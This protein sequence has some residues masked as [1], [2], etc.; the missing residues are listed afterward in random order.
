MSMTFCRTGLMLGLMAA[1]AA[2][3]ESQPTRQAEM[4]ATAATTTASGTGNFG[5]REPATEIRNRL[6]ELL[7]QY[8]PAV[9]AVLRLSPGLLTEP[10]YL[11]PYPAL[12]ALLAEHPEIV[13]N[14]AFYLGAAREGGDSGA[15]RRTQA[16]SE[17]VAGFGIFA[18]LMTLLGVL[19]W[20]LKSLIDHQR[21]KRALKVQA[22]AHTK[23]VERLSSTED[24]LAYAQSP[25]GRQFLESGGPLDAR[26]RDVGAPLSR[27]LWSVQMGMVMTVL[28]VGL[29]VC[30]ASF[31]PGTRLG[32]DPDISEASPFLFLLA[33]VSL[34]VG[35]GFLLSSLLSYLL[36]RRLGLI[37]TPESSHA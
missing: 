34:S 6:R 33:A 15:A 36:S 19:A 18:G 17:M 37:G 20:L 28:G 16:A 10:S 1:V 25:A 23:L 2:A 13:Q 24:V 12:A 35:V 9:A 5:A 3:A 32:A 29:F 11:E 31:A 22:D 14:P 21:W 4:P 8:P 30:S 27:I 7:R 26:R